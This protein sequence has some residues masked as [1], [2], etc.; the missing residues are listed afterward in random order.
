[1]QIIDTAFDMVELSSKYR[2]NSFKIGFVPTMGALHRGHLSLITASKKENDISV[3]SVFVNPTQFNESADYDKYPRELESDLHKLEA[4]GVDVAFIPSVTTIYP[5][6]DTTVH[7]LSEIATLI[8]GAHRPG[9]FNGVASVVKRLLELTQP[10]NAY[11]GLKDYQQYRIVQHLVDSYDLGTRIV[12][13]PIVREKSGLAMSSRNAL[14]SPK[15]KKTAAHIY[16][17]LCHVAENKSIKNAAELETIGMEYLKSIS[18]L[19]PEYFL[20]VDKTT[21][22]HNN[23]FPNNRIALV[24]ARVEGV[25]LIDNIFLDN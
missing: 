23:A 1:M 5:T 2:A 15:G 19:E 16:K 24:A 8:E 14:L 25:R 13:C 12:G 3:S 18:S 17:S 11:F 4:S 21:L 6:A 22:K 10:N 9:H 7:K 20:V